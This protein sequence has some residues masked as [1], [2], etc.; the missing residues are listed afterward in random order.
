[1]DF[2]GKLNNKK[3]NWDHQILIA[4]DR[5][6]KWPTAKICKLSETKD[7]N[8][9]L[10]CT[11]IK[12]D[13]WGGFVSK[14]YKEFSK[15][16]TIEIE[17]STPSMHTGTGAVERAVQT[18]KSLIIANVEDNACLTECVNRALNVMRFKLHTGLKTTPFELGHGRKP[19]IELTNIIKDGKS[20]LSNWSEI[21][22]LAYNRPKI[23]MKL[24]E[25]VK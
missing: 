22:V 4:I 16:K 7:W 20:F 10:I 13:K 14:E 21:P 6:S 8:K 25:M 12:M 1:M 15:P 19:R 11:K 18:W 24:Q 17:N 5:L 9:I 2:S 23:P 3:L